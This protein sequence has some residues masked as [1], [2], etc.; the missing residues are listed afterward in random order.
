MGFIRN[1]QNNYVVKQ[2]ENLELPE[3]KTSETRRREIIFSGRVQKV[4]FRLEVFE[5]ANRLGLTGWVQNL[6]NGSVR[7]QLQGGV[8]RIE[9]LVNFMESLKRAKV[10]KVDL[11]E[12]D[13]QTDETEFVIKESRN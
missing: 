11:I 6:D 3:F 8:N 9:F 4:G 1:W 2:V 10:K 12:L 5:L 13:I 7:T